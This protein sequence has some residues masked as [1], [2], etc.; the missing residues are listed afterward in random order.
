ML[1]AWIEYFRVFGDVNLES[2]LS[3]QDLAR[4]DE[5][6]P[7]VFNRLMRF[8]FCHRSGFPVLPD[9]GVSVVVVLV[10]FAIGVRHA[11]G[12]RAIFGLR[13]HGKETR[14]FVRT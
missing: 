2:D 11:I 7:A 1:G 6:L 13:T 14:R 4:F 10:R 8:R 9:G 12:G 5:V 3:I